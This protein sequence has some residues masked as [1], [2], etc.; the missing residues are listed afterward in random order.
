MMFA[1]LSLST[2]V[3]ADDPPA[4]APQNGNPIIQPGPTA[5][6]PPQFDAPPEIIDSDAPIFD[7]GYSDPMYTPGRW[8]FGYGNYDG[9]LYGPMG[10][11]FGYG[12]RPL[13]YT[14]WPQYG[15]YTD[16]G[17]YFQDPYRYYR[18]PYMWQPFWSYQRYRQYPVW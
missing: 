15:D 4:A 12:Y 2:A 13:G 6:Q 11:N 18:R 16:F 10:F 3:M 14:F 7:P 1:W 9:Y 8:Y 5:A 17:R